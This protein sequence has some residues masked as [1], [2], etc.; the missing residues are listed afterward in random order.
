MENANEE[1]MKTFVKRDGK[2][3]GAAIAQSKDE[4]A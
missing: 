2:A 1:E 3:E 4:H